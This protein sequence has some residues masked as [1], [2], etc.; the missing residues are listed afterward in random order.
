MTGEAGDPKNPGFNCF[1]ESSAQD[2]FGLVALGDASI[3]VAKKDGAKRSGS[4]F[5]Q[6]LIVTHVDYG[7]HSVLGVGT[8]T[9]RVY[10]YDPNATKPCAA[11]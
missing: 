5:P 11:N 4:N 1:G 7:W 8:Y 6:S 2:Y 9:I 3:D 10:F